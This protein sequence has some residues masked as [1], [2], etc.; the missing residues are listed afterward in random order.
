[1]SNYENRTHVE[2]FESFNISQFMSE[3]KGNQYLEY[4]KLWNNAEKGGEVPSAP[5][6]LDIGLTSWCNLRCK[7]CFRNAD[8]PNIEKQYMSLEMA[9]KI[10]TECRELGVYAI[11]LGEG[12]EGLLH[13]QIEEIID[14]FSEA[15]MLEL[16]VMTNGIL[17]NDNLIKKIISSKVDRVNISIDAA[18]K[19]TYKKIRGANLDILEK[20]IERFLELR[21]NRKTPL[22]RVSFVK[23]EE[24]ISE[25]E[26]FL[27]KWK[28]KADVVDFQ[29]V[30][31]Y[32]NVDKLIQIDRQIDYICPPPFTRLCIKWNG[33]IYPCSNPYSKYFKIGNINDITI[34][35]AW[36]SEVITK[37][38]KDMLEKNMPLA[39]KNCR[40]TRCFSDVFKETYNHD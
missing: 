5:M 31:N 8:S 28:E 18:T 1:M 17:L 39:C 3:M 14:I 27:E 25:I 9:R 15:G 19:E 23:Q 12:S 10:A 13:P 33:D 21:G 34:K 22:L 2:R 20:N 32:E 16:F 26:L 38:R 35:M 40:G 6:H 36:E 7:M 29:D 11:A 4:R 37:L 30:V 24:N